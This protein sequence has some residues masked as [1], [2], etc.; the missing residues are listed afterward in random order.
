MVE[1]NSEYTV[2]YGLDK[3][4]SWFTFQKKQHIILFSKEYGLGLDPT[5]HSAQSAV[6]AVFLRV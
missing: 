4:E 5:Q 1:L 3:A 2:G 6:G